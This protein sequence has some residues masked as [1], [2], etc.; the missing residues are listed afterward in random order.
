MPNARKRRRLAASWIA[1]QITRNEDW[2]EQTFG[3]TARP[4]FRPPFG[5]HDRRVDQVAADLGYT[6]ILMWNG[7]LGDASLES[8]AVLIGLAERWLQPGTIMLGHL[9]Y[10]TVLSLFDRLEAIIQERNLEP[11]TLDEMFGTARATG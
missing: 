1:S 3:I 7:T 8:P 2:I 9:N 11:V 5:S 10:P 6:S 4:Y